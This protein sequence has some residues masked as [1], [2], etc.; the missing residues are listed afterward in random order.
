M[1]K[2]SIRKRMG[3]D[4]ALD[5]ARTEGFVAGVAISTGFLLLAAAIVYFTY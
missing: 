3:K 1:K 5:K 4:L 2:G